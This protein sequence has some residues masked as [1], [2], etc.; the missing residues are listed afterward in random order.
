MFSLT[1]TQ[2]LVSTRA[3]SLRFQ[4]LNVGLKI[5]PHP[6]PKQL[7]AALI[8][9]GAIVAGCSLFWLAKTAL[10]VGHARSTA[11]E[12]VDLISSHKPSGMGE[13]HYSIFKFTDTAGVVR[14]HRS[15]TGSDFNVGDKISILYNPT[16]PSDARLN[17]FRA[18]WFM[19]LLFAGL[20]LVLVC[21]AS[22]W[23]LVFK[24]MNPQTEPD[25]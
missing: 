11:A 8:A 21:F 16:D 25:A 12:V 2:R 1:L 24:R 17:T 5:M 23:L 15:T 19:P 3:P 20:G 14:T 10:F 22:V 13:F 18:L 4:R 7:G 9:V 6:P